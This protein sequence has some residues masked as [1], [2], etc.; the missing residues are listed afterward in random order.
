MGNQSIISLDAM[1]GDHGPSVI[2]P[3]ALRSLEIHPGLELILVG[4]KRYPWNR[5]WPIDPAH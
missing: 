2:V 5:S 4:K 3:A 1:G